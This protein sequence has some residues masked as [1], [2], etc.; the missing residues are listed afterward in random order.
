M[1]I[2]HKGDEHYRGTPCRIAG[3]GTLRYTSN[4]SCVACGRL[5]GARRRKRRGQDTR[6]QLA[7]YKVE[8]AEYK[9]E[10]ARIQAARDF[11]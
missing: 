1:R 8:L 6:E 7:E 11:T 2:S 3:H 9:V 4:G 5:A 10:L